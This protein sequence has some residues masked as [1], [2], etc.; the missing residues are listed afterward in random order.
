M[1]HRMAYLTVWG[2]RHVKLVNVSNRLYMGITQ[3]VVQC[4]LFDESHYFIRKR[5]SLSTFT[6]LIY[7]LAFDTIR[8]KLKQRKFI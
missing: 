7:V 4:D 2:L 3:L 8:V 5:I 6:L 1:C